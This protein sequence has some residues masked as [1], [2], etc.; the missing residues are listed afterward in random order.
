MRVGNVSL[1]GTIGAAFASV[2]VILSIIFLGDRV[3]L[4]QALSI[5]IIF[6]GLFLSSLDLKTLKVKQVFTD[7]GVPYALISMVLWGIYFTFMRIPVRQVGWFWPSY[8]P[9]FAFPLIYM[10]MKVKKIDL[11]FPHRT[12]ILISSILHALMLSG[13]TFAYNFA[14]MK[15]QT[16]IV[17]P[18][19]GSYPVLFV[20]LAYFV[21]KDPLKKQQMVGIITTLLGIVLLSVFSS[22]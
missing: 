11:K 22:V 13:S 6:I 9:L 16:V 10:F 4:Y 5:V 19:A 12:N 8:V 1:V 2:T 14:V 15:G 7:K 21:F 17:T 18:I 3:N 20:I